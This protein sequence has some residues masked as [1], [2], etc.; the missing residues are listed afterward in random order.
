M[1]VCSLWD[2]LQLVIVVTPM[3]I[4]S[5]RPTT[6]DHRGHPNGCLES[7]GPLTAGG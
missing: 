1:V 6:A 5:L 3:V 2:I 4:G 7:L